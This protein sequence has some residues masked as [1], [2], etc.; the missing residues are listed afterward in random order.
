[1]NVLDSEIIPQFTEI[2]DT[3]YNIISKR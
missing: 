3:L 2:Y 1:M